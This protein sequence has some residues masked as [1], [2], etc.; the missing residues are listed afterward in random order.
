MS[1]YDIVKEKDLRVCRFF[2]RYIEGERWRGSDRFDWRNDRKNPEKMRSWVNQQLSSRFPE[3]EALD[4]YKSLQEKYP[5]FILPNEK[6]Y[7]L[8]NNERAIVYFWL[9]FCCWEIEEDCDYHMVLRR[10]SDLVCFRTHDEMLFDIQEQF[11]RSVNKPISEKE[12]DLDSFKNDFSYIEMQ[13]NPLELSGDSDEAVNHLWSSLERKKH[14]IVTF[15]N[16]LND[17]NQ[18]R[19]A[20]RGYFDVILFND[21]GRKLFILENKNAISSHKHRAKIKKD[22]VNKQLNLSLDIID[23]LKEL[24]LDRGVSTQ[25]L[26][27]SLIHNAYTELKNKRR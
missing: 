16:P 14:Q 19:M 18:K 12:E 20:I 24:T 4:Y 17:V 13:G 21:E 5:S 10:N 2:V 25:A 27:S 8:I 26:I 3:W 9:R 23:E 22:T 7:F 6:F 1:C 15:F 11:D